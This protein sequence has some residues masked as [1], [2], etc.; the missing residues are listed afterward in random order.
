M[1]EFAQAH[2]QGDFDKVLIGYS[3][4]SPDGFT[5]AT[6]AAAFTERLGFLIAHRPGFVAPTLAARKAQTAASI[7]RP[8]GNFADHLAVALPLASGNLLTNLGG[9]LPIRFGGVH[10][11]AIGVGGGIVEQDIA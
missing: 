10:V 8:T 9:G 1:R 4:S 3:S 5:I 2:E 7:R 11:G 6:H